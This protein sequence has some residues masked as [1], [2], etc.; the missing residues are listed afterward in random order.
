MNFASSNDV[1]HVFSVAV[2][3]ATP[4]SSSRRN[5][6]QVSDEDLAALAEVA[7]V[8]ASEIEASAQSG[9]DV[10]SVVQAIAQSAVAVETDLVE[11]VKQ[12]A[13]G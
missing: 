7:T 13:Q 9:E 5:L 1:K 6:Q 8:V 2:A 3:L 4:P 11:E 10:S 12:L